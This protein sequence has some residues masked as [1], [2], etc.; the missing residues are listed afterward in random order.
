MIGR[1]VG[2]EIV[3]DHRD[4]ILILSAGAV[5][6]AVQV[7][8]GGSV[9]GSDDDAGIITERHD[10]GL[11]DD[12][13]GLRPG[14][15]GVVQVVIRAGDGRGRL[16]MALGVV[17]AHRVLSAGCFQDRLGQ[18]FED[19][20]ATEAEDKIGLGIL[21]H[22]LH[23]FGIGEMSV[24]AQVWVSGHTARRRCNTRLT[25]RAFSAPVGRLPGR[26]AAVTNLP[27]SPSKMN[28]GR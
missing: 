21:Q 2:G 28:S 17:T 12:L 3:L 7:L 18:R 8:G 1:A 24:P 9:E 14:L 15:G 26:K 23:Q 27:D 22:Q 16:V 4:P 25:I 20:V 6:I 10:L 11:E 5:K 19:S 13:E